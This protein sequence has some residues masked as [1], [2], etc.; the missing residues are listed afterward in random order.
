MLASRLQ[1]ADTRGYFIGKTGTLTGVVALSGVLRHRYDGQRY[2]VS[3]LM[4]DVS[5][6]ATGRAALDKVVTALSHDLLNAGARPEPPHRRLR[7]QRRER[8]PTATVTWSEV[9]SSTAYLVWRSADGKVWDRSEA[10]LVHG[11]S[12]RT[13]PLAGAKELFVRL[14]AIGAAGESEPSDVY[15]ARIADKTSRVLLVDGND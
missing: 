14:T 5:D 10:R 9:P 1:G 8:A 11:T 3:M 15:G 6:S 4:N 2:L 12:H 13:V 7:R